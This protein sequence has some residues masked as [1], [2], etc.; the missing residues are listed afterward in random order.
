VTVLYA[1]DVPAEGGDTLFADTVATYEALPA[2]LR[3]PLDGRSAL[4][5]YSARNDRLPPNERRT[6]WRTIV[7]GGTPY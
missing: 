5:D 3:R 7:S 6:L 2:E 1:L 4:H